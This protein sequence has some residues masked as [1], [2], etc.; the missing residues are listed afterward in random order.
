MSL[1]QLLYPSPTP[2]GMD[3]WSFAHLDHHRTINSAI[4][5]ARGVQIEEQR[6]YPVRA[7]DFDDF[8]AQNQIWHNIVNQTLGI[9]GVD[10][11]NV[12]FTSKQARDA[13]L[14]L[15]FQSHR[16]WAETLGMGI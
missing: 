9:Q 2:R 8:L 3:E 10:L 1:A 4:A 16:T 15:H 7:E 5:R 14:F 12:D 13:W 6:I 11:Q